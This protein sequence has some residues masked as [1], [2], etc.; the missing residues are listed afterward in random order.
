MA[1][2]SKGQFQKGESG[3]PSGRPK[4]SDAEVIL[5]QDICS[6]APIAFQTIKS[7]LESDETPVN[8]RF[9][10]CELVISRICGKDMNAFQINEYENNHIVLTDEEKAEKAKLNRAWL[11]VEKKMLSPTC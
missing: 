11:E 1:R 8:I 6:L 5:L 10:C 2:N 7:L 9:R 4:R 3:N